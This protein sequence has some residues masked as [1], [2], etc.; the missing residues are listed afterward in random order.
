MS[1]AVAAVAQAQ[2]SLQGIAFDLLALQE[3][4]T[5][6]HRTLP[7]PADLEDMLEDV[8]CPD[9]ATEVAGCV[10]CIRDDYL[11]QVIEALEL[12]SRVTSHDLMR[13]FRKRQKNRRRYG[14]G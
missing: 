7:V 6:I 4:L 14:S 13:D 12:A 10:E 8:V 3:R 9:L 5:E 2:A 1:D 11:R